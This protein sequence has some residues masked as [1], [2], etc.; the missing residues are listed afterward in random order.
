MRSLV[1][2]QVRD[3]NGSLTNVA[4]QTARKH[5]GSTGESWSVAWTV[6]TATCSLRHGP[7]EYSSPPPRG[8]TGSLK[9]STGANTLNMGV[10]KSCYVHTRE[11]HRE[12][13]RNNCGQW[14]GW[15]PTAQC[16]IQ[17]SSSEREP[18]VWFR[19]CNVQK[20]ENLIYGAGTEEGWLEGAWEGLVRQLRL[21]FILVPVAWMCT[22]CENASSCALRTR[23]LFV[24]LQHLNVCL[25]PWEPIRGLDISSLDRGFLLSSLCLFSKMSICYFYCK[26]TVLALVFLVWRSACLPSSEQALGCVTPA[27]YVWH[28][29]RRAPEEVPAPRQGP[30]HYPAPPEADTRI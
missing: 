14:S 3:V 4:A 5:V 8:K 28:C 23:I 20:Q 25:G 24:S 27:G 30:P 1:E 10:N 12:A 29:G 19:F 13:R 21:V 18:T 2:K 16:W 11:Y 15:A 17:K 22:I 9:L 7:S 6:E 26:T